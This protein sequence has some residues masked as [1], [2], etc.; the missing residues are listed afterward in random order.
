MT[1]LHDALSVLL[2]SLVGF[3]LG[4]IGG[5]GSILTVPLLVYVLGES[6]SS[7]I[8]TSLAIVGLNALA[9]FLG[10]WRER[11]VR[12]QTGLAFGAVGTAG[13]FLGT[14]LGHFLPAREILFLFALLMIVAAL[15]MVRR[16]EPALVPLQEGVNEDAYSTDDRGRV[17]VAGVGVGVLTGFFG[18]GG[19][20]VVVPALVIVL[21]L[22]MRLAVGTSL[23]IIA[24]NSA[25]G[26]IAHLHYGT[27]SLATTLLF[28]A[29]G[30]VGTVLGTRLAGRVPEPQLRRI[31]AYGMVV[32]ALY[33]LVKD[34]PAV[35]I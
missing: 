33:L 2:G 13:A 1:P 15:A 14:W 17:L 23:L 10:H 5:G 26:L 21:G 4:L 8:G 3:S 11:R 27:I 28:A 18:V 7:A 19:G 12:L 6:V 29:G 24:I 9:G 25:A 35:V 31:F 30:M 20:F 34:H 16:T 22:P 32:V